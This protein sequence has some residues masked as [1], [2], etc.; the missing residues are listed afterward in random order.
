[1]NR[2]SSLSEQLVELIATK[3]ITQVDLNQAASHIKDWLA[4]AY[5]GAK[6]DIGS[7]YTEL[8]NRENGE[9]S[10]IGVAKTSWQ[11]AL[12]LNAALGNVLE[13]DDIHRTSILHPGPIVIPAAVTA[14]QHTGASIS[15]FLVA[16]IKGYEASIRVGEAIGRSHY[17]YFHNTST[18]AT[19][20]ACIAAASL[21]K[22]N[23][24]QTIWA[25]GNV[26]SRTGGL[27][28]MRNEIVDTK[29]WHNSEA[30]K[31]GLQAV[32][33]ANAGVKG[34]AFIFEGP[35]GIFN[36]LSN[37]ATPELMVVESKSWRI[38]D[39]S[40][41]PW[42]ACRHAHAAI[43]ATLQLL[44]K[45]KIDEADIDKVTVQTY[46]DA[47]VFCDRKTPSTA[48]DAKFS[49]QHAVASCLLFG[50][51]LLAHYDAEYYLSEKV[52]DLRK[53]VTV[54][55]SST[56]EDQYPQ[57]YGAGISILCSSGEEVAC[58]TIDT[59]GDPERPLTDDQLNAKASM[60]LSFA[61][62]SPDN[63]EK[64]MQFDWQ[65]QEQFSAFV[66]LLSL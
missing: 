50:E 5:A 16:V 52:N 38:Y 62:V 66:E 39:C 45:T 60:L 2:S 28:Q 23:Q 26:G 63:I 13:M 61:K 42:P 64:I 55:V 24:E 54:V 9:F 35:Q 20:G 36:A 40:F 11:A 21:F 4:C 14:A 53:K 58:S 29:Q 30:A 1:M 33:L 43:D 3:K 22:L 48:L 56:F 6:S 17:H 12:G 10:A 34:P 49:I 18:C 51:P 25:L 57:H 47:Q 32:L 15:E 27:W 19:F 41:K 37:D 65:N 44:A 46:Q 7:I 8:A 31:A 59:L